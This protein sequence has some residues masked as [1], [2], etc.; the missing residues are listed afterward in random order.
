MNGCAPAG[1]P[2]P[3]GRDDDVA[4]RALV[5]RLRVVAV[6]PE[7]LTVLA[8]R[9]AGC[10][11]CAARKGCG[12]GALAE[13]SRPQLIEIEHPRA[14]D[15]HLGDEIEVEMGGNDFL[16]A[17]GLAYLLPAVTLVLGVALASGAGFG[18]LGAGIAG[19]IALILG[20]V[21][22]ALVERRRKGASDLRAVAVHPAAP[23]SCCK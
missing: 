4:P 21:P 23:Q 22:V 13:L 9:A 15:V 16:A 20:F 17:A 14:F 2:D 7:R 18:D 1:R 8:D 11:S 5:E 6:G 19:G 3:L 12:A 10:A